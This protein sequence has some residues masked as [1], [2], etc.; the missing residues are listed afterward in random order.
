MK[1]NTKMSWLLVLVIT[2][3]TA[4]LM[5][6]D[7]EGSSGSDSDTD[8]DSDADTDT[9]TDTDA[10]TDTDTDSDIDCTVVVIVSV[11][12]EGRD[13]HPLNINAFQEFRD[14]YPDVPLL[15]FLNAAYYTKPDAVATDVT[16]TIESVLLPIDEHGLHIHGWKTLFEAAGVEHITS[17]T[18]WNGGELTEEDCEYDCGH[19]ISISEYTT[20]ELVQVIQFSQEIHTENGFDEASSFRTGGWMAEDNVLEALQEEEFLYD[21]S[22]VPVELIA[23]EIDS[24]TL[25]F[26]WLS[27]LWED[28]QV[29]SQP[30]EIITDLTEVPDNACL[31]DYMTGEDMLDVFLA[32]V[33]IC[34]D[35]PDNIAYLSIGFHQETTNV[36]VYRVAEAI[37]LITEYADK[38]GITV[39]FRT[40]PY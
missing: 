5:S 37:D 19:E 36:Y 3:L 40:R 25:I 39:E 22:S 27:E 35:N 18:W 24:G 29:T 9:D 11:D 38:H 2:I 4:N 20:K 13:F 12:W 23:D 28:T 6:C 26:Q 10:D 34:E 1:H 32:N 21:H 15:Q 16:S 33:E 8:T 31:A 7:D 17:P 30:Y 14:N